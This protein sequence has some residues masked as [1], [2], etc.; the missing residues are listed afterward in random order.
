MLF[1]NKYLKYKQKYLN[2]KNSMGGY[3]GPSLIEPSLIEPS[4][5][6]PSLKEPSLR[7][8]SLKEPSL[9][10]VMNVI[11]ATEA[12]KNFNFNIKTDHIS[13]I[14]PFISEI[15][16]YDS[17]NNLVILPNGKKVEIIKFDNFNDHTVKVKLDGIQYTIS[18][19]NLDTLHHNQ[20]IDECA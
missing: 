2:L 7:K 5:I 10:K 11:S 15:Y 19:Y 3:V 4:L 9:R 17:N 8:P 1:K 14:I 20:L 18:F 13:N 6:E 16:A 12:F